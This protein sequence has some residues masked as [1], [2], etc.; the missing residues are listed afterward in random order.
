MRWDPMTIYRR[1]IELFLR[2][3][4][5]QQPGCA[6]GSI[7]LTHNNSEPTCRP[8]TLQE[9]HLVCSKQHQFRVDGIDHLALSGLNI[10]T[11]LV[12]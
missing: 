9:L 3:T 4:L 1:I 10:A 6:V 8:C 11:R 2:E 7:A 12:Q 5:T